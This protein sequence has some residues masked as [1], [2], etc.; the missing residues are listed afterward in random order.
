MI[1]I[2]SNKSKFNEKDMLLDNE[3]F[4]I[5][6]VS[7]KSLNDAYLKVMQSIDQAI[8]VDANIGTIQTPYGITSIDNLSIGC[9]TVL[10]YIFLELNCELYKDVKAIYATECGWNAIEELFKQMEAFKYD[11]AVIIEHDNKLY[12]C[13]DREYCIDD[14]RIIHSMFDR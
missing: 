7:P 10:N 4:F 12:N 1:R 9:K 8:L 5:N 14:E 2:Y 13:S 3:A 11:L 6:N